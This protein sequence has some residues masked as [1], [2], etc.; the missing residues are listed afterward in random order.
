MKQAPVPANEA[1]RLR[2][3]A[4]SRLW[5]SPAESCFDDLV[6]LAATL[7]DVPVAWF[8]LIDHDQQWFKASIGVSVQQ[9][10]RSTS[11]CSFT[12]SGDQ[13]LCVVDA[14]QDAVFKDSPFVTGPAGLRAYLGLPIRVGGDLAIGSLC[15][16]DHTP[17][18][19]SATELEALQRIA[20][21]IV[22]LVEAR[23]VHLQVSQFGAAVETVHCPVVL[24]ARDG[25]TIVQANHAAQNLFAMD[26]S[27]LIGR[28]LFDFV[29]VEPAEAWQRACRI[30]MQRTRQFT[31]AQGL[32]RS[33]RGDSRS[34]ELR[35]QALEAHGQVED[36][37]AVRASFVVQLLDATMQLP[38]EPLDQDSQLLRQQFR[39]LDRQFRLTL[40][41]LPVGV[42]QAS[43]QGQILSVNRS[44]C[45]LTGITFGDAAQPD[46][47]DQVHPDE[48]SDVQRAWDEM[49]V[50]RRDTMLAHRFVRPDGEVV[51]VRHRCR[52]VHNADGAISGYLGIVEDITELRLNRKAIDSAREI[53]ESQLNAKVLALQ[54]AYRDLE[55]FSYSV[56][57]D[58]QS[59]VRALIGF[60]TVLRDEFTKDL[61]ADGLF[62]LQRIEAASHRM[63]LMIDGLL[64]LAQVGQ[65]ALDLRS[66][67]VTALT[68][69]VV[70]AIR[71]NDRREISVQI[72]P[73][74]SM[75]V[76][77]SMLTLALDN[78][79]RNAWKFTLHQPQPRIDIW[80]ERQGGRVRLNVRDNGAGMDM[81]DADRIFEPFKR[82][83]VD[84]SIE[85]QG[86]GLA[87]V[88]RV[89]QRHGGKVSVSSAPGEGACFVLDL[90][91]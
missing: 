63:A 46:W 37:N 15:V 86:I 33:A 75:H 81:R 7:C 80:L 28:S 6:A 32:L 66:V 91:D 42:Y 17:R 61:D 40:D 43:A 84:S 88:R 54:Q 2:A 8:S 62:Y 11:V 68:D 50:T 78:L 22:T 18:A 90:P 41:A 70:Q 45:L 57:H 24:L 53:I 38:A 14:K 58:L 23:I 72:E 83:V 5:H 48:R 55:A 31:V 51:W 74:M 4:S 10:P 9:L 85:G 82:L 25:A 79:L 13:P 12:I 60:A 16:A 19:F 35:L 44:W 36:P 52:V 59:P 65:K 39:A 71:D 56:A 69:D 1:E 3:L 89:V 21:Q 20:R 27:S 47:L 30:L 87:I 26:R 64:R 77:A 76:D 67:D 29:C 34:L 73:G 49:L